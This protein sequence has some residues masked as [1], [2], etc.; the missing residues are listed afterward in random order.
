MKYREFVE[1]Y[2]QDIIS[3]KESK[4]EYDIDNLD[5]MFP[6][7]EIIN[8]KDGNPVKVVFAEQLNTSDKIPIPVREILTTTVEELERVYAGTNIK[9]LQ[10]NYMSMF[11]VFS[12]EETF[13]RIQIT[14]AKEEEK[15]KQYAN[16]SVEDI[17]S[18]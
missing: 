16:I 15:R 18:W 10:E 8:D 14:I 6:Y 4:N 7:D 9:Q 13:R 11:E 17:L 12:P 3:E 2:C 1:M 5:A